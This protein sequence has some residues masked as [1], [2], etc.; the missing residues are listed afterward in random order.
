MLL[1]PFLPSLLN[2]WKPV[3]NILSLLFFICCFS[4]EDWGV[5][6]LIV[7]DS[8]KWQVGGD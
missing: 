4:Y 6:E 2:Q 7:E 5:D 8:W 1:S 3:K